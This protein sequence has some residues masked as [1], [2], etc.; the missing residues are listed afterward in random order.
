MAIPKNLIKQAIW[1][2]RC[3][4]PVSASRLGGWPLLPE[5]MEWPRN[6]KTK[7]PLHFLA[8]LDLATLPDTP[9]RGRP[10][11][12]ALPRTGLL[13]F[14]A[15]MHHELNW[16]EWLYENEGDYDENT[17]LT[18]RVIYTPD[19]AATERQAPADLPPLRYGTLATPA[20]G[21]G[22]K[23]YQPMPLETCLIEEVDVLSLA[24]NSDE[25]EDQDED[26]L[27]QE[28]FEENRDAISDVDTKQAEAIERA[29]GRPLPVLTDDENI[30]SYPASFSEKRDPE[31]GQLLKRH[32]RCANNRILGPGQRVQHAATISRQNGHILLFQLADDYSPGHELN[33]SAGQIQYWIKPKD[34]AKLRFD[35]TYVT[36]E[37]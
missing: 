16:C 5:A 32:G 30:W 33:L 24:L 2:G 26:E 1:F 29:I 25:D 22:K 19:I 37:S 4:V 35:R 23:T 6:S 27:M 9:L 12:E 36:F 8:Q 21:T 20:H 34:L 15:D 31:T 18:S 13:L 3:E 17:F 7:L 10:K 28:F 11:S 14:F